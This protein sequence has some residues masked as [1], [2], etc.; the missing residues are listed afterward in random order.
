MAMLNNQRVFLSFPLV[1]IGDES[2][3]S[4]FFAAAV[5][6]QVGIFEHI[7]RNCY[8]NLGGKNWRMRQNPKDGGIYRF[9]MSEWININSA[10]ST[11]YPSI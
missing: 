5:Q 4:K 8:E 9:W 10:D 1:E 7:G 6:L 11:F 3:L 2:P